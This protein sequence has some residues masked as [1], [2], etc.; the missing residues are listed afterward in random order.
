MQR[1]YNATIPKELMLTKIDLYDRISH[2][3]FTEIADIYQFLKSVRP[4]YPDKNVY[5]YIRAK[6]AECLRTNDD[7]SDYFIPLR[8]FLSELSCITQSGDYVFN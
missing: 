3:G 1:K 2:F 8:E 4:F 5:R 6:I 7:G